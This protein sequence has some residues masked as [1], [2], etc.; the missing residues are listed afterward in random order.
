[1]KQLTVH[2][3]TPYDVLVGS[4]IVQELP[5]Q[6]KMRF[7]GARIFVVMDE[8]VLNLHGNALVEL[9]RN[10][11][12]TAYMHAFPAGE[13]HKN[14]DTLMKV[15]AE[16]AKRELRR[17][18]VVLAFGGGV[19][20]DMAGFA[21]STYMRGLPLVMMPTTLL[22]MADSSIGGKTAVNLPYVKNLVGT[23]SQPRL[24]ICDTDYVSTLPKREYRAGYAEVIKCAAIG[25]A[26]AFSRLEHDD[27]SDEEAIFMA[28]QVKAAFV[29]ADEFDRGERRLLNFGHTVG[30]AV[31]SASG[32]TLRHGE[33]VSI[34][35]IAITKTGEKLGVTQN[36]TA[37]RLTALLQSYNLPVKYDGNKQDVYKNLVYDKK[38]EGDMVDAVLLEKIGTAVRHKLKREHLGL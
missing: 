22:A 7:E 33:A 29:E 13:V 34:G 11:G 28:L 24:V 27:M 21:A 4:G 16:M 19:V 31:E 20:G 2:T 37:A 14:H 26:D 1:M 3:S 8:T 12:L 15:Y 25:D 17:T 10:A 32:Y 35:M 6:L 9:L 23:F 30:H 38:N 18:D 5:A 36:G